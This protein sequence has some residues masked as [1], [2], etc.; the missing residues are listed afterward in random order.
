MIE[1]RHRRFPTVAFF[2]EHV[3]GGNFHLLKCNPARVGATLAHLVLVL[4]NLDAGRIRRHQ[5]PADAFVALG[6]IGVGNDEKPFRVRGVGDPH[7]LAVENIIIASFLRRGF[8]RLH[9]AAGAR[10]GHGIRT[11][12][13]LFY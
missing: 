8:D 4:A 5:K 11:K 7:F 2:T 10:F 3:S 13:K 1:C 6:L 9:V 12:R